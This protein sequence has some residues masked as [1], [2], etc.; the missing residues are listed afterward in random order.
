M[1]QL[2]LVQSSFRLA[3][4]V[5]IVQ[6]LIWVPM[7][8]ELPNGT[9]KWETLQ[10]FCVGSHNLYLGCVKISTLYLP[11][12]LN[13]FSLK[14]FSFF[15]YHPLF[16]NT[17]I[18]ILQCTT[19]IDMKSEIRMLPF[20][21]C[22]MYFPSKQYHLGLISPDILVRFVCPNSSLIKLKVFSCHLNL[23]WS[24]YVWPTVYKLGT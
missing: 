3:F 8:R 7:K 18:I 21:L 6:P 11:P 15:S 24:V 22:L 16:Y 12:V 9:R 5:Q 20:C 4:V 13:N 1:S 2:V 10:N 23:I 17:I 19:I 14:S